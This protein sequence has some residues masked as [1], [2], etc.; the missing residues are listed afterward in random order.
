MP[1]KIVKNDITKMKVDAIV[2]AAN[3]TLLGN[4]RRS[5]VDGRIHRAAGPEL[6]EECRTLFGCEA[7]NAKITKGYNLPCKYVIHTVGPRWYDG[8]HGEAELLSSCYRTSLMLAKEYGCESIAF[9]IIASG[10]FAYPKEQA[11]KIANEAIKSFLSENE[12]MVYLVVYGTETYRISR[13]LFNDITAYIDNSYV[14]EC[15]CNNITSD[16]RYAVDEVD[17]PS[18]TA[19]SWEKLSL[20]DALGQMDESFSE[21]LLS[22]IRS[23]HMTDVECYKKANIDRKLFSKIKKDDSYKPSKITAVAF[24]LALEMP[25]EEFKEFLSTAGYSL[26]H[27]DKFDIIVEYFVKHKNYDVFEIND[28][29]FEFGQKTIGT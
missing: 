12:M 23:S 29:L 17:E 15:A 28:V 21:V 4:S 20:K 9:P 5:G 1:L 10:R 27:S 22:K 6:L 19:P 7:G 8:R 24:G 25:L 13:K 14:S 26:T 11:I 2:N 3:E 16:I 18:A